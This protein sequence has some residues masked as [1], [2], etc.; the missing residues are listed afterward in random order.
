MS[1]K[2]FNRQSI[3]GGGVTALDA[4][5]SAD[6]DDGDRA[7]ILMSTGL[8]YTYEFDASGTDA[9]SSPVII[10]PDDYTTSGVWRLK[11]WSDTMPVGTCSLWLT[12]TPPAQHMIAYGQAVSRTVYP[13]LF[14]VFGTMYG[15]GDGSTSFNLPGPQGLFPRFTDNG[16]GVD[17]D[18]ETRTD[19]GDGTTGDEVGTKQEDEFKSH[20]HDKRTPSLTVGGHYG[21]QDPGG[22][23]DYETGATGGNETRPKNMNFHLIIK[24]E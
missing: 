10:R 18:A 24:F 23:W 5:A 3:T 1:I 14:A 2:W 11:R 17:P 9:E 21:F 6:I 16:A 20:T 22:A 19:R 8:F 13:E 4:V 7:F 15:E 12:D